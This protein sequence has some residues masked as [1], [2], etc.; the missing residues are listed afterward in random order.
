DLAPSG[1]ILKAFKNRKMGWPEYDERY[2][3][4]LIERNAANAFTAAALD[5]ACF[6]C[7][8]EKPDRCHRRLAAEFFRD[9]LRPHVEMEII[10]L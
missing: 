3:A 5:G 7:S 6:L 4:L 2:R 9:A 10:H 1:E 8:E